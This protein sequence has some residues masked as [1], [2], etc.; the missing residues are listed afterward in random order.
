M[1]TKVLVVGIGGVGSEIVSELEKITDKKKKENVRFVIMDTDANTIARIQREGFNGGI[2]RISRRITVGEYLKENEKAKEW[3]LENPILSWKPVTEGAG[4]IRGVSRLAFELANE[5]QQLRAL[6]DAI[7]ELHISHSEEESGEDTAFRIIIVSTLAGGT[8]SGIILPLALHLRRYMINRHKR[9]D[10]IIRGF[11]LMSDCIEMVVQDEKERK[12]LRGNTYATIKEL[13]AFMK[14][15]DGYLVDEYS[16]IKLEQR[17]GD[18]EDDLLAYNF[19]Y[20]FSVSNQKS[21]EQISFRE[22]KN[23]VV[24]CVY[25]QILGPVQELNNSIEDNVLKST[26]SFR[27][28]GRSAEFNRYCSAGISMLQY[29]YEEILNY[30]TVQKMLEVIDDQWMAIDRD[31]TKYEERQWQREREGY[32]VKRVSRGDFY[33][34]QVRNG[35]TSRPLIEQMKN[36]VDGVGEKEYWREYLEELDRDICERCEQVKNNLS[37]EWTICENK[38]RTLRTYKKN[39]T[40][41]EMKKLA[42]FYD[43]LSE[44]YKSELEKSMHAISARYYGY[45]LHEYDLKA[46]HFLY[47]LKKDGR[48]LHINSIRYFI[49]CVLEELHKKEEELKSELEECEE[50]LG[51]IEKIREKACNPD[52]RWRGKRGAAD[53]MRHCDRYTEMMRELE[54]QCE[55]RMK[56]QVYQTGIAKLSKVSDILEK[57]YLAY[58]YNQRKLLAKREEVYQK[59]VDKKNP[60]LVYVG[61]KEE[62]LKELLALVNNYERDKETNSKLSEEI[63]HKLWLVSEESEEKQDEKIQELF[64]QECERFWKEN[65]RSDYE[66]ELDINIV[67][68]ILQEGDREGNG[69]D[70]YAY[71]EEK[72]KRMWERTIPYLKTNQQQDQGQERNFC[73]Y[74]EDI[75]SDNKRVE[76]I[77]E[78]ELGQKGGTY[79]NGEVDKY[80]LI[81]YKV[82]YNLR[83]VDIQ[84]FSSGA[85]SSFDTL[86]SAYECPIRAKDAGITFRDYYEIIGMQE[87]NRLTPH[88]DKR[89][90]SILEMP[91]LNESFTRLRRKQLCQAFFLAWERGELKPEEIKSMDKYSLKIGEE[92]Y[93]YTTLVQAFEELAKHPDIIR[94]ILY[95]TRMQMEQDVAK[96]D[97]AKGCFSDRLFWDNGSNNRGMLWLPYQFIAEQPKPEWNR[98][99]L[100]HLTEAIIELLESVMRRFKKEYEQREAVKER[101]VASYKSLRGYGGTEEDA[102]NFCNSVTE[103]ICRE[104]GLLGFGEAL[105]EQL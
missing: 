42:G 81:F 62:Q 4:Q 24:R 98:K 100:Y 48:L 35:D 36:E 14:K 28:A 17:N 10:V 12:S 8:G 51:N 38:I 69:R 59:L 85:V 75:Y 43:D 80:T 1:N 65:L 97:M 60:A 95:Q 9:R 37:S 16:G 87:K 74:H 73:T 34:S 11:F 96:G 83:V 53:L 102:V 66:H 54:K 20:L 58:P 93:G 15:A 30:L 101:I 72:L 50:K 88:I 70:K 40:P 99:L 56:K 19:C 105:R 13:D 90:S 52:S 84:D 94:E 61:V 79:G 25:T 26:M 55:Y 92:R 7:H 6:Y 23:Y 57:F 71:L 27:R 47:W 46:W 39:R 18:V 86:E 77:L 67:E 29:P 2:A 33:I 32:F 68:A 64:Q 63:F 82:V 5:G 76:Q 91:D 22:L 41:E 45:T 104:K 78:R 103:D 49:Y 44:E 3:F 21:G 89:W 31:Y